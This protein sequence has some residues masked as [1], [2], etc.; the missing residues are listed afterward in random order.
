MPQ[1]EALIHDLNVFEIL[2]FFAHLHCMS[3]LHLATRLLEMA[4]FLEPI[5]MNSLISELSGGERRKVS[6]AIAIIHKPMLLIL[7]EPSVCLDPLIRN[8]MWTA[9]VKLS[10]DDGSTVLMTTHYYQETQNADR[11]AFMK[12]GV[13]LFEDSPL[14][15]C[16]KTNTDLIDEAVL[17]V[18]QHP[19]DFKSEEI[20]EEP[21][22]DDEI[23]ITESCE[24]FSWIL[25]F[26]ILQMEFFIFKRRF[27]FLTFIL[28]MQ[29]L[30]T[31]IYTYAVGGLPSM[32]SLGIVENE[33]LGCKNFS[34]DAKCEF[35]GKKI[36]V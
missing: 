25:F 32:I 30:V 27:F 3:E 4:E 7:D 8:D 34:Y 22:V 23:S 17:R 16:K 6:F 10:K 18:L 15:I 29:A 26:R 1:E 33:D 12:N 5:N 14:N 21:E 13:F 35:E 24:T 31:F 36:K 28:L 11:C 9:L 20:A 19:E 2:H